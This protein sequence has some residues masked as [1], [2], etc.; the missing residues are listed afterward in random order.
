MKFKNEKEAYDH[1]TKIKQLKISSNIKSCSIIQEM[2][3]KLSQN[4]EVQRLIDDLL[5]IL[6]KD[7]F[8]DVVID[9]GWLSLCAPNKESKLLS[10]SNYNLKH[11]D[12]RELYMA[13]MILLY[14]H[15]IR[16]LNVDYLVC[17]PLNMQGLQKTSVSMG[18]KDINSMEYGPSYQKKVA[19]QGK[20][21]IA[22]LQKLLE[23]EIVIS[24]INSF[25]GTGLYLQKDT[26]PI[27][28]YYTKSFFSK[29]TQENGFV[30]NYSEFPATSTSSICEFHLHNPKNKKDLIEWV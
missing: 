28:Y 18:Y 14:E 11:L 26:E 20:N 4:P 23:S 9:S 8:P 22:D 30:L 12:N 15:I 29:T 25:N 6:E 16:T 7:D 19:L 1:I 24:E 27:S 10:Y 17:F 3:N 21:C 13:L 2:K 5:S